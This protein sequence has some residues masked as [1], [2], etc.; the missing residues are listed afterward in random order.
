MSDADTI[1]LI[2]LDSFIDDYE[3]KRVD[4]IKMDIEGAEIE[5]LQGAKKSLNLFSPRIAIASYH[6]RDGKRT[7]EWV[8]NFL[9]EQGYTSCIAFPAHLTTYGY[10][11]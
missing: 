8:E 6:I 7:A 4:F 2:D 3:I 1:D 9:N 5:A 10:K 11:S